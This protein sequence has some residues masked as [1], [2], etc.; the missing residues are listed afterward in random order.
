MRALHWPRKRW[1]LLLV[2]AALLATTAVVLADSGAAH[3][4]LQ[5]RP[6]SLGVS[7]GNINDIERGFCYT[8]TL[9]SLVTNDSVLPYILSNNHVLARRNRATVE[10][11]IV[12]PGLADN[13]CVKDNSEAV[14]DLSDFVTILFKAKKTTPLNTVDAAIAQVR[15][16]KVATN[17]SILDI[18]TLSNQT[19]TDQ[20]GCAVQK[21]G[22]TTGL[23]TGTI[24]AV[25]VTVDVNYGGG[26]VARFVD[27][28]LITPGSF[29][30]GGDSGSLIARDGE[31]PRAVGLLFAGS[32]S[33]TIGNPIAAVLTSFGVS[34]VGS[35]D[36][37]GDCPVPASVA[38][39]GETKGRHEQALLNIP[40]VVGVGVGAGPAIEVYVARGNAEAHRHIP[41][42]LEGVPVRVI[43]T[44]E[45]EAR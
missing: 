41:P 13:S 42:Q 36:G 8:G 25:N 19:A 39:A 27:Q 3:R 20:V 1:S 22:R 33:Y 4:T 43:L 5:T 31:T 11:D 9:G 34:M 17:G 7:G 28:F 2:T 14:A 23:T 21:S 10:D 44:G 32:S 18:G 26:K 6:I 12:Q 45:F 40:D 38:S 37:T 29:S 24:S 16:G 35:G 15:S 30:A